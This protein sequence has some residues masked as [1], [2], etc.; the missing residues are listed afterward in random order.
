MKYMIMMFGEAATMMEEK[1]KDW[2]TEMIEFMQTLNKE[3]V[4]AGELLEARG[5]T[6]GSQARTISLKDGVPVATDGP[7]AESK[8]SLVG[9]WVLDVESEE[10]LLD[11][12]GRIVVYSGIVEVRQ[13]MDGPPEI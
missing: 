8:E 11:I 7:F 4:D 2:I 1:P 6:D 12:A 5:L 3:L 9:Y 10:R 13:V